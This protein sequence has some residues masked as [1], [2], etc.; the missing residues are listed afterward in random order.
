MLLRGGLLAKAIEYAANDSPPNIL[1]DHGCRV[2]E[3]G[4]E[5][6]GGGCSGGTCYGTYYFCGIGDADLIFV[7]NHLL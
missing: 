5:L 4:P 1:E 7:I 2:S 3:R 6:G